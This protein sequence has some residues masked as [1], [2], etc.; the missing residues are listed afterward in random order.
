MS[1]ITM[2]YARKISVLI[3]LASLQLPLERVIPAIR[4]NSRFISRLQQFTFG[5]R[6]VC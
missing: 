2:I 5:R 6:A 3:S 1:T 4:V